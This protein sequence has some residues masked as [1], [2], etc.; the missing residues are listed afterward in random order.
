MSAARRFTVL[1]ASRLAH[2]RVGTIALHGV[3][4]IGGDI[5]LSSTF[6]TAAFCIPPVLYIP[7]QN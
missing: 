2:A 4:E 3:A 7:H 5:A 6:C 1:G